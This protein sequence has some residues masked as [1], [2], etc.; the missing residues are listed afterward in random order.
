MNLE[1]NGLNRLV[2][3]KKALASGLPLAGLLTATGCGSATPAARWPGPGATC[4]AGRAFG[5]IGPDGRF[6]RCL[7]TLDA[8]ERRNRPET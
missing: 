7:H 1:Q 8:A 5:V 4:P 3:I 2:A 6:R